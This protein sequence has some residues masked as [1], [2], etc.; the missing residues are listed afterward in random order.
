MSFINQVCPN[1]SRSISK[2][3]EFCNACGCPT[4]NAWSTCSVC[5]AA[6]GEDSKFCWKCG[7]PQDL[8]AKRAIY[9]SRWQRSPNDF[10]TRVEIAVPEKALQSG[11]QV[12][13]GTLAL[14]FQDGRY[15]GP[16]D[17]GYHTFSNFFQRLVG[18]D[19]G[20]SM[21]AILLD[22]RG[23]DV[24]FALQNIRAANQVPFDVNIRLELAVID[25]KQFVDQLVRSSSTF[26]T[27]D[28]REKFQTDVK[29]A[30]QLVFKD[31]TLEKLVEEEPRAKEELENPVFERLSPAL[32]QSGLRL[33]AIRSA[34]F[35]GPNIGILKE[36]LSQL[37]QLGRDGDLNQKLR[38]LLHKDK[39]AAFR[40]EKEL[41][42]AY[43]TIADE[44]GLKK[45]QRNFE[46]NRILMAAQHKDK[47]DLL[48]RELEA[49]RL[50]IAGRQEKLKAARSDDMEQVLHDLAKER[51]VFEER[52]RQAEV[53][54][55]A[56]IKS[57]QDAIQLWVA[58]QSGKNQTALEAKKREQELALEAEEKQLKMRDNVST[59]TLLTMVPDAQGDRLLRLLELEQNHAQVMAQNQNKQSHSEKEWEMEMESKRLKMRTDSNLQALMAS[60]PPQEAERLLKLAELE[61]NQRV[62]LTLEQ[63]VSLALSKLGIATHPAP[64]DKSAGAEVIVR[65]NDKGGSQ[66]AMDTERTGSSHSK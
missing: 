24:D 47:V 11:L 60:V 2:D 66:P 33:L 12:D 9:G 7:K 55:L 3:A 64:S 52:M 63:A 49:D 34:E 45:D 39:L 58:F 43:E 41:A 27:K 54:R 20:K 26:A 15:I 48:L 22:T 38:D 19:K 30:V 57:G 61:M 42:D 10:A 53:K 37:D 17:A 16:L 6:V 4:A 31:W 62:D 35:C 56:D 5:A 13:E 1:C 14:L 51:N 46:R 32:E 28:L 25:P 23:A 44:Y 50:S 8:S 29:S 40:D 18:A 21:H 36:R 65:L 59:R